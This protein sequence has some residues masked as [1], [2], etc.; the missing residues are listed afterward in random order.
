MKK[1]TAFQP[2]L[3]CSLVASEQAAPYHHRWLVMNDDDQ[4][5]NATQ[6]PALA[7][8]EV[9]LK[10]GYLVLRCPGMIRLDIPLDVMEDDDSVRRTLNTQGQVFDVV[11][12]G[13]LPAVWLTN[14]CGQSCRLVKVHPDSQMKPFDDGAS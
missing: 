5:M 3:G 6:L 1:A 4:L 11:D 14:A 7:K 9:S 2:I 12:E 8:V 13:D 10:F